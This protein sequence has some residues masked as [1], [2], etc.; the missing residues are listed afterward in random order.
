MNGV[1]MSLLELLITAKHCLTLKK[2]GGGHSVFMLFVNKLLSEQ[3]PAVIVD[4]P[5]SVAFV[6]TRFGGP[7]KFWL[8][9]GG[10]QLE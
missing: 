3:A 7:S 2:K 9:F 6:F 4:S 1:T 8:N 5:I 10:P